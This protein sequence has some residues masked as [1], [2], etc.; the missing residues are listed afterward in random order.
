MKIAITCREYDKRG[1]ISRYVAELA[2]YFVKEHE[3]HIYT[4]SWK[5]VSNENIIFHKVPTLPGPLVVRSVPLTIQ[6]T[7]RFSL[8]KSK[9]DYDIVHINGGESL[10]QDVI[11]AHS[12]HK[13]GME[14]R[15]NNKLVQGLGF[16][17]LY[18]LTTEK[19]NYSLARRY[20]KIIA[21]ATSGKRELMKYYG[22]PEE[23]IVV[24]PLPVNIEE[25]KPLPEDEVAQLRR[26][27]GFEEGDVVLLIVATEFYRKGMVELIEAMNILHNR[28]RAENI[29]L[30]VVGEAK[31]E[32]S[33]KGDVF[34]RELAARYNL[35]GS[36]VFAGKKTNFE[37]TTGELTKHYNLADIFVFPTKYEGFGIPTVEAM[38]CEL[39]VIVSL[40]GAG[41]DLVEDGKNGLLLRDPNNPEEIAEKIL[42][43]SESKA[44]R[45]SMGKNARKTAQECSSEN[46]ARRTLEV[47]EEVLE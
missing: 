12:I 20:K 25:F 17:D 31:V 7:L 10:Y 26:G 35:Q 30:L 2:E 6:H 21:D 41:E 9:Y 19:I 44:L 27:Y 4:T 3:V 38:A 29:K 37:P 47:Y 5:D 11:T 34:Y 18:A 14:F 40:T 24:I 32:G 22:V 15:K 36:V 33:L 13:A 23:D 43:L 8:L 16:H 42:Y 1:G 28:E 46:V 45:S 39:P